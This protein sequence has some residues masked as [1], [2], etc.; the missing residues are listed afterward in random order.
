[1]DRVFIAIIFG[2]SIALV[3][4]LSLAAQQAETTGA[5]K[6]IILQRIKP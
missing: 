3:I 1:M 5:S 2:C 4:A 6:N